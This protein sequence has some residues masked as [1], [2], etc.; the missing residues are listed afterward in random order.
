M[1]PNANIVMPGSSVQHVIALLKGWADHHWLRA[2]DAELPAQLLPLTPQADPLV[3]F[4]SALLSHQYGRGHSCIDLTQLLSDP[5]TTLSLPPEYAPTNA[6]LPTPQSVLESLSLAELTRRLTQSDWVSLASDPQSTPL[7][8]DGHR[9]YLRRLWLAEQRI[10]HAIEQRLRQPVDPIPSLDTLLAALFPPSTTATVPDWQQL[11]CVMAALRPFSI[12]TGGPGTGKTTTVVKLLALLQHTRQQKAPLNIILAAPTGKAAARLSTSIG[13]RIGELSSEL[14]AD[15]HADVST[16]HRM[17]GAIPNRR[18]F[19]YNATQP[20]DADLVVIDEASMVDLELM[21]ALFDALPSHCRLILLGDKDQ[22]ASVEA[23]SVLGDLCQ[24]AQEGGYHDDTVALLQAHSAAGLSPWQGDGSAANQVTV[25]LRESHRFVATSGIGQLATAVRDGDHDALRLVEDFAD[26]DWIETSDKD[27]QTL[28]Q[29]M[30]RG[31]RQYLQD[32]TVSPPPGEAD[33]WAAGLLNTYANFQVLCALR[34]GPWGIAAWNQQIELWL[35]Q[36]GLIAPRHRWY[37]GRPVMVQQNNYALDLMNGDIG[38]CLVHPETSDLRVAFQMPDKHIRWVK[39]S[40]LSDV[41]TVFA[42]TVHKSQGSEFKHCVLLLP[43]QHS[44]L[45]T[46][47]LLYT[48]LTRASKHFTLVAGQ[49]QVVRSTIK[50]R[51]SR[52]SGL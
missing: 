4:C 5:A 9:L 21:A 52:N 15:L 10:R 45:L 37:T 34:E 30:V 35:S 47:E 42:M 32:V 48:G 40:R 38:L 19:R 33:T 18:Q 44:P 2:L 46:R 1:P 23:G 31:Y 29:L 7:V 24:G 26:L 11:A 14:R 25:M 41:E 49:H 16:L 22:L 6:L 36:S 39:P 50:G 27:H 8:L 28:R 13:S 12:I 51:V 3:L 43:D 17:L 20:L